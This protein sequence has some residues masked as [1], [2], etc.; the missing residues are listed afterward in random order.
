MTLVTGSVEEGAEVSLE[1]VPLE[2]GV[3]EDVWLDEVPEEVWL[4]E[5]IS[6]DVSLEDGV[7]EEVWLEDG[8]WLEEV[9]CEEL[10][11]WLEEELDEDELVL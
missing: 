3:V 4:E 1:E 5:G 6:E 11:P 10:V 7:S 8:S 9:P 2:E